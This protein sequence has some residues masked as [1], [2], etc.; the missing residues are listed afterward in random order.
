VL[1]PNLLN[2]PDPRLHA[3]H[4]K[5]G[6]PSGVTASRLCIKA[7]AADNRGIHVPLIEKDDV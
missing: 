4:A 3:Q 5:I 1:L 7:A 6:K 2:Q